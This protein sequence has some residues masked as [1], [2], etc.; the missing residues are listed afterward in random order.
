[1]VFVFDNEEEEFF[2]GETNF[3]TLT[4]FEFVGVFDGDTI[5]LWTF[6]LKFTFLSFFLFSELKIDLLKKFCSALLIMSS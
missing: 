3:F 6:K 4:S 5:S 1:M 2:G